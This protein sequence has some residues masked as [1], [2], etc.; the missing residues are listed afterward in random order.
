[1][2]F[3]QL[4]DGVGG[5]QLAHH[6]HHERLDDEVCLEQVSHG[7]LK[8]EVGATH[9]QLG[10]DPVL[11]LVSRSPDRIVG[12]RRLLQLDRD[13]NEVASRVAD[14]KEDKRSGQV[15]LV[16]VAVD[17]RNVAEKTVVCY[18]QLVVL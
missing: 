3:E 4:V 18:V 2:R 17:C 1:V 10:H 15:S 16:G 12:S 8:L 13:R 6:G 7:E 9:P 5:R 11:R 14:D